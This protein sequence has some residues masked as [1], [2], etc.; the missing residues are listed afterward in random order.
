MFLKKVGFCQFFVN[1][2]NWIG[3]SHKGFRFW[4]HHRLPCSADRRQTVQMSFLR[5]YQYRETRIRALTKNNFMLYAFGVLL[6]EVKHLIESVLVSGPSKAAILQP[7]RLSL[8]SSR[9]NHIR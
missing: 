9:R 4:L 2:N 7:I 1:F 5:V 3:R 8:T 6:T